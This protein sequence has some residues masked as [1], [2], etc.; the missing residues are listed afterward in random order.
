MLNLAPMVRPAIAGVLVAVIGEGWCFFA[1]WVSYIAVIA[2]LLMMNLPKATK[3]SSQPSTMEHLI[4]GFRF[5][6]FTGLIREILLLLG[7]VSVIGMPYTVLMPIFA[8]QILQ[9]GLKGLGALMASSGI[10]AFIGALV[11]AMKKGIC[12]LGEGV[13]F[14]VI[15][16]GI[17]LILFPARKLF[18]SPHFFLFPLGFAWSLKGPRQTHSSKPFC[19]TNFAVG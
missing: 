7:L 17:C 8:D 13:A 10:G 12:G 11:L 16:F 14:G 6:A 18:G 1:N 9:A 5:V 4:E 15:G 2:G 19:P 3:N